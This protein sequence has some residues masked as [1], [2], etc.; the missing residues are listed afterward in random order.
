MTVSQSGSVRVQP[1]LASTNG[2]GAKHNGKNG[3]DANALSAVSPCYTWWPTLCFFLSLPFFSLLFY[4]IYIGADDARQFMKVFNPKFG[5]PL[6]EHD[7]ALD[8]SNWQE[9]VFDPF[10]PSHAIGWMLFTM[11]LR[12]WKFVS[13]LFTVDELLEVWWSAAHPNFAECWYVGLSFICLCIGGQNAAGISA[14]NL[15]IRL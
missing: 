9:K 3:L 8:C 5:V 2:N 12:D 11:V 1:A 6:V 14:V 7:Y 4:L 13:V 10:L 15:C